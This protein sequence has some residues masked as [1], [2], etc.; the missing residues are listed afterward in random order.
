M[1]EPGPADAAALATEAWAL[2][3]ASPRDAQALAAAALTGTADPDVRSLAF[4]ALG[5]ASLEVGDVDTS[6]AQLS[7]A[8][9][10]GQR[11]APPETLAEA[12]MALALAMQHRGDLDE[13][14]EHAERAVASA[15]TMPRLLHQLGQIL[16][17]AT[18]VAD[19]I[20]AYGEAERLAVAQDDQLTLARVW[21][22]RAVIRIYRA[23]FDLAFQDLRAAQEASLA[24]GQHHLA[25]LVVANFGFLAVR[26][27]DLVE[28]LAR[29]E[30]VTPAMEAAGGLRQGIHELD[31][32]EVQLL[33]GMPGEAVGSGRIAIRVLDAAG[34]GMELAE[35]KVLT[36]QAA[37]RADDPT[38]AID[39][40]GDALDALRR[41]RAAPWE[42]LA[43]EVMVRA[44]WR[45]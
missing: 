12:Q 13:A 11:G 43:R 26:R 30:E 22:N 16:E 39:L 4:R 19:A 38:L 21:C 36:A 17:R 37:L 7:D 33:A 31:R 6:I 24:T 35:A 45:G 20:E 41:H 14:I 34:M 15:P 27:G 28:A 8:V 29:L 23:E 1:T 9:A 5:M 18:R 42:A 40:A 32:C 3:L 2:V 44:E 25:T 10:E